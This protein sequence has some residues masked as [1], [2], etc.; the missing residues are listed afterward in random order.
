MCMCMGT[1]FWGLFFA[2]LYSMGVLGHRICIY[3]ALIEYFNLD[4]TMGLPCIKLSNVFH[5]NLHIL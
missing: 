4:Q 5:I 2:Y 3:S 1:G